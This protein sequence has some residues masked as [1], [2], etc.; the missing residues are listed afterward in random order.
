[1]QELFAKNS[2]LRVRD[3]ALAAWAGGGEGGNGRVIC[4]P[5]TVVLY[6]LFCHSALPYSCNFAPNPVILSEAKNLFRH[7]TLT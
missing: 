6:T 3:A 5:I 1:M 2:Y 7:L 4:A